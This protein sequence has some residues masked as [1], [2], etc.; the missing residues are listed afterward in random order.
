MG[1]R[2]LRF[3]EDLV[4]GADAFI[5]SLGNTAISTRSWISENDLV[6]FQFGG[7]GWICLRQGLRVGCEG[8]TGIY[9]NRFKFTNAADFVEAGGVTL[10]DFDVTSDG[11]QI[12]FAA[13]G[14][15]SFVADLLP[16]W[17]L[18]G[19]YQVFYLNSLA[20]VGGNIVSTDISNTA[21]LHTE[22]DALLHGVHSGF[23]YVW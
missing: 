3:T 22:G 13:E 21:I 7:D 17:S 10:T 15:V 23:E 12:A 18:R 2:Y 4:F 6:G 5:A 1:A 20:T 16:S 8:K 14:G 9:N 19:G 11:N